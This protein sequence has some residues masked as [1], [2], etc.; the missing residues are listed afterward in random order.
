[1]GTWRIW[2]Y[3][4][5]SFTLDMHEFDLMRDPNHDVL[6]DEM[7]SGLKDFIR[8]LQPFS[9]IATPPCSTYSRAR[10]FYKV[11]PGPRPIRSRQ[12]PL[13][14]PWLSQS[15]RRKA[16]EG[17]LLADR[18]WDLYFLAHEMGATFLGE[19]PEDLGATNTGVPAS[20]WQMQQFQEM[21]AFRDS[22]TF[23]IF[24]CEFGA[25]TPK[26]TRLL[27]VRFILVAHNST[28]TGS[29]R[30]LYQLNALVQAVMIS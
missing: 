25:Q 27:K 10:H 15:N 30:V 17:R 16:E 7:W 9:V 4:K 23:A 28:R 1:M 24:Q 2:L 3:P 14:F 26:P 11:S 19:F 18:A 6:Q 8:R 20:F 22:K 13:G 29:I 12:H 5:V 21:L